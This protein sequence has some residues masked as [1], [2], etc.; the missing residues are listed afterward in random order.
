MIFPTTITPVSALKGSLGVG[1]LSGLQ[2]NVLSLYRS[3]LRISHQK[4]IAAAKAS[5]LP[6]CIKTDHDSGNKL[7]SASSPRM[8]F[9][10]CLQNNV[11]VNPSSTASTHYTRQEFRR[12][13]KSVRRTDLK[14]IEHMI[15][16][17]EK[18]IKLLKMPGVKVISSSSLS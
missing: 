2:R 13:A 12:R 9:L 16:K 6:V 10:S 7:S 5:N 11:T 8:T 15:R 4:D 3:L 17:G 14:T 18:H 1:T